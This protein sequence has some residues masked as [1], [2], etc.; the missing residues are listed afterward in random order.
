[1]DYRCWNSCSFKS[2]QNCTLWTE[3]WRRVSLFHEDAAAIAPIGTTVADDTK[4]LTKLPFPHLLNGPIRMFC[5]DDSF[6]AIHGFSG[7]Q[8]RRMAVLL[9]FISYWLQNLTEYF[10]VMTKTLR[11][12]LATWEV[13]RCNA[14][15]RS[16]C[17]P[18]RVFYVSWSSLIPNVTKNG[19]TPNI[20]HGSPS[21]AMHFWAP[22]P[23]TTTI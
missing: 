7:K 22:P 16:T 9:L 20:A 19:K 13:R 3:K 1:M 8:A 15:T 5:M 14:S 4:K 2:F 10:I 21:F 11:F 12:E 18:K 17:S 23:F 6:V